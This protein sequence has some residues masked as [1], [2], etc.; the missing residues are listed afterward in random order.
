MLEVIDERHL[1][2]VGIRR[3]A[4]ARVKKGL[5]WLEEHA[6][7]GYV[8]KAFRFPE[9]WPF[10][11][12]EPWYRADEGASGVEALL[13]LAFSAKRT[14]IVGGGYTQELYP[15]PT[16]VREWLKLPHD[17]FDELGLSATYAD[18]RMSR[19][20]NQQWETAMKK[21]LQQELERLI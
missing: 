4:A 18:E 9:G 12:D 7:K 17:F 19:E 11:T 3:L 5:T 2:D 6:P 10:C 20:L 15:T 14:S 13:G 8:F 21:R 1:T 16:G